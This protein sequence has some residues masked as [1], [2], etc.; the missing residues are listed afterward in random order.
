MGEPTA[1]LA[2]LS[3]ATTDAETGRRAVAREQQRLGDLRRAALNLGRT[4]NERN[5][6]A[7]REAERLRAETQAT[8]AR[9]AELRKRTKNE[10]QRLSELNAE[11]TQVLDPR[12]DLAAWDGRIPI[13]LFPVRLET[14][15][16]ARGDAGKDLLVRIFPDECSV[17]AFEPDLST[18]EVQNL[19]RYWCGIWKAG[20]DEGLARAAWRELCAAHGAGRALYLVKQYRPLPASDP[21][22]VRVEPL[23]ILAIP[24]DAPLVASEAEAIVAFSTAVWRGA[25]DAALVALRAAVGV[26]RAD[27]L[28][29]TVVP[30]N[31]AEAVPPAAD[32]ATVPVSVVFVVMTA[33]GVAATKRQAWTRPA[34]APLLP[35]RFVLLADS[36]PEHVEWLGNVIPQPLVVGPDPLAEGEDQFSAE[37]GD[38]AVPGPLAWL[39]DFDAAVTQGLGFRIALSE[40]QARV[41]F[42][43]L[44]VLGVRQQSSPARAKQELET[45]ITHQA[46]SQKGFALVPQ[47]TPTN[48]AEQGSSG[49]S[50]VQ[51]A[52]DSFE[53]SE[54]ARSDTPRFDETAT[55]PYA[56]A[57]GLVLADALGIDPAVLQHVPNADAT[58]QAESRAMNA[59]LWPATLGYFLDTQLRPVFSDAIIERTRRHFVQHVTGRGRLPAIRCGQQ[60][61]GILPTTAYSRLALDDTYL[62]E[63]QGVLR[64]LESA[65]WD[66]FAA[67]APHVGTPSDDPQRFL[68]ELLGLNP[69]SV[70]FHLNVLDSAD[71]LWNSAAFD[72]NWPN[73]GV[74]LEAVMRQQ[75]QAGS[76]LL[77]SFGYEG[78]DPEIIAKFC[79][80]SDGAMNRPVIDVAPLSE[81]TGLGICTLDGKNYVEWC[82]DKARA[83]F[84][85][86]RR[87]VGFTP[88]GLP[89]ALFYH[90]LRHALELGYHREAV[91]LRVDA[92]VLAESELARVYREPTFV[93]VAPGGE[94]H[95]SESRYAL[96]YAADSRVTGRSD[97][98]IARFIP[99]WLGA[100]GSTSVLAEQLTALDVLAPLPTARLERAFAEHIDLASYRLDAWIASLVHARLAQ[101]R[102]AGASLPPDGS[103]NGPAR[104]GSYLGAFGWVENLRPDPAPRTLVTLEEP[105]AEVF[106]NEPPLE[107][108]P[109]NG[110]H[111]LAPSLNHAT[112]AAVL[113]N[114]YL[115]NATPATPDLLAVDLSSAR[116][117]VALEF[118]EGMRNGQSLG[119]LLGYELERRLHD[120]HADAEVDFFVYELR[121]AFPLLAKRVASSVDAAAKA[122]P[123][124]AVEARN[125]CDGLRLLDFVRD[126]STQAYPWGLDLKRGSGTEEAV[127]NQ[128]VMA[129]FEIQDAIADLTLAESLHQTTVGN[130]ERAAAAMDAFSK[131]GFPPEPD[132]I[133]T[134][135]TGGALTH[136]LALHLPAGAA[137]GTTPRSLAEPALDRYVASLLPPLADL[138][139]LVR[140]QNTPPGS[141]EQ[142]TTV[143]LAALGL[144]PIDTLHLLD[145]HS[146]SAMND[147]D[148]RIVD[149]VLRTHSLCPDARVTLAY[150]EP[151]GGKKTLFELA[152]LVASLR[153]LLL[154]SRAL[155]ATDAALQRDTSSSM[156]GGGV[157]P[158]V[159]L[160][161]ARTTLTSLRG[162]VTALEASLSP[163]LAPGTPVQ[164][165][166]AATDSAVA[167]FVGLVER[168]AL[169]GSTLGSAGQALRAV[170]QWF[171]LVRD[172]A[173]AVVDGWNAK[174][175]VCDQA[176]TEAADPTSSDDARMTALVRAEREVTLS[177]TSPL[178]S[179]VQMT[180]NVTAA[181]GTFVSVR[182]EI[183]AV[184]ASSVTTVKLLWAAWSATFAPRKARDPAEIDTE[185]ERAA[186]ATLLSDLVRALA[187]LEAELD[188]RLGN[189]TELLASAGTLTGEPLRRVLGDVGKALLGDGFRILPRFALSD[190]QRDEWQKA[191]AARDALLAPSTALHDFP[192]DEWLYGVARVRPKAWHLE[193]TTFLTEAFALPSP[194]LTPLQFPFMA[195]EGWFGLELPPGV[196]LATPG[197]RLLYTVIDADGAFD[198]AAPDHVGLLLDEWTEVVPSARETAGLAFH[199][200]R[201]SSEPP[202]ALLLVLPASSSKSW[203]WTDLAL[204]VPE[205]FELAKK[206]AAEPRDLA[207]TAL[208]RFL[209]ATL[210]AS[211][212]NPIS[213]GSRLRAFDIAF[214]EAT[215]DA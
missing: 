49:W 195:G 70:E 215:P 40:R 20:G 106:G 18:A 116:V 47:G 63:L 66:G 207:T 4:L 169:C 3:A 104:S 202:Q 134:P 99:R 152:P 113:R 79:A 111:L 35:E 28:R 8:E 53:L 44:Y 135:R 120:R 92:G 110:G 19:R 173:S 59:A 65:F 128:E 13:L 199:Y 25:A 112:T 32:R 159:R 117:R 114:G 165:L 88:G 90:L 201:P 69:A 6:A 48:N 55:D 56:R 187:G 43:R 190:A 133:R 136:R 214:A 179:L 33:V 97:L 91:N 138:V 125:V 193:Q 132:V 186:L 119:A 39:T 213:I 98:T 107:R 78:A 36:G 101:A 61:Y 108:D 29:K 176:L 144:G 11:L 124:D 147:L 118:L 77:R 17:D 87:Q 7:Q 177:H 170:S 209:P 122:A 183:A 14:R 10:Q 172:E 205:T 208:S 52:D 12:R 178:P 31:T 94:E 200:D 158:L 1:L 60:P 139:V 154:E 163:L 185:A 164:S 137:V 131:G 81:D 142:S 156:D 9:L 73:L 182:D 211:T 192:A 141:T 149:H 23:V 175:V 180:N 143:S 27:E 151:V 68:L 123:I 155:A 145:T 174:L 64:R 171:S 76:E 197:E 16:V 72:A 196:E 34:T 57:D 189:A 212:V 15:F 42:D 103:D 75:M 85:D 105:L 86:L 109:Q 210:M 71:R 181:R 26:A 82:R 184:A 50:R 30:F 74:L 41:G 162:E 129:L 168:A 51:E 95:A 198:P 54:S 126:A 130:P 46:S 2:E 96:L 45:L 38:L 62:A 127:V 22:P 188:K 153:A 89:N 84:D 83:A 24:L 37:G 160:Q 148:D 206:R 100:A 80:H 67:S 150:T 140:Y 115:V 166:V 58:D 93:H 167:S 146:E 161:T 102:Q 203:S 157:I 5:P 194:R 204:A 191:Y 121:R 21:E